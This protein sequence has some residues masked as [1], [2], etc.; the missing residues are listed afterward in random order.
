M[1]RLAEYFDPYPTPFWTILR[2]IGIDAA[3]SKLDRRFDGEWN[4]SGDQPWDYAPL[5]DMKRR[6]ESEGFELVG[7]EDYPQMDRTRLGLPGR[8]EEIEAFCT[9]VRNMGQARD[10]DALLQLDGRDQLGAHGHR[11]AR[12]RRRQ[13]DGV[14]ARRHGR[15]S[16]DLGGSGACRAALGRV[17][18]L[19]GHRRPG[20][21]AG[22]R[23]ARAAPR[24]SP[25]RRG[26]RD[27]QDHEQRR[28]VRPRDGVRRDARP[29]RSACARATS[30]SSA[31]C[32]EAIRRFGSKGRLAFGHFRDVEGTAL[33]FTE[34]FHDEGMTDKVACM[35]AWHDI[36]F[37]VRPASRP[38]SDARGRVERRSRVRVA[39]S[40]P[41]GRVP[42]GAAR[43]NRPRSASS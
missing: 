2:Q 10:P 4:N 18:A 33:D 24:R 9:L 6:Y 14:P 5:H 35:Q 23:P 15:P 37:D 13:G 19:H 3:I 27:Q 11:S 22:G 29:T 28:V 43:R 20:S 7:I 17:G 16:R 26:P 32:P 30:R 40:P 21:G 1:I 8:D 39:R 12:A 31:T 34:T 42:P 25:D 41:R 36:G 38:R